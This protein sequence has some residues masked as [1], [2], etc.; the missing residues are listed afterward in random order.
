L[1]S[2]PT[3]GDID[4][5]QMGTSLLYWV[6]EV[7]FGAMSIVLQTDYVAKYKKIASKFSDNL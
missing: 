5:M 2:S 1:F 3:Y 4:V 6:V 7:P